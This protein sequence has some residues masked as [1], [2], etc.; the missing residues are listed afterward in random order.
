[1]SA[2]SVVF[3]ADVHIGSGTGSPTD[4]FLD[5]VASL[6]G[7]ADRLFILGDLFE[8]WVGPADA[9]RADYRHVLDA[10]DELRRTGV[11]VS[12][13]SGNRDFLFRDYL[14][15]NAGL[16]SYPEPTTIELDGRRVQLRHGDLLCK[17]DWQ[18]LLLRS[19]LRSRLFRRL[20]LSLPRSLAVCLAGGLR[21]FSENIVRGKHPRTLG[22]DERTL[23]R[24]FKNGIDVIICG[25]THRGGHRT[26]EI[27][28]RRCELFVLDAWTEEPGYL[29]YR[30]G[31]FIR[32]H[33]KTDR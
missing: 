25:H 31:E 7:R 22:L 4:H 9:E 6:P 5:F 33:L 21:R 24:T 14:L 13:V 27:G 3:V 1:M 19:I 11:V 30:E 2:P 29:E 16:P 12:F 20:F 15:E 10:L 18:N 8:I 32:R 17:R 23:R 26:L 28:D